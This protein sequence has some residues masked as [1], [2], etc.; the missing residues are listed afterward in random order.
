[1]APFLVAS[2]DIECVSLENRFPQAIKNWGKVVN[3]II[4]DA[5][6]LYNSIINKYDNSYGY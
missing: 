4:N 5:Q 3:D 6:N 2:F 1:M